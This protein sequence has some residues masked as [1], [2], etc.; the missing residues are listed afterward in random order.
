MRVR[1]LY[2]EKRRSMRYTRRKI[3]A[4]LRFGLRAITMMDS[5]IYYGRVRRDINA[6][7]WR[8]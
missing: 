8:E 3:P 4:D 7:G 1:R 6:G 5:G 2:F